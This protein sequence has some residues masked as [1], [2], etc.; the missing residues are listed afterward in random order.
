MFPREHRQSWGSPLAVPL[1]V[2]LC[3]YSGARELG[4]PASRAHGSPTARA[5]LLWGQELC[6]RSERGLLSSAAFVRVLECHGWG[7]HSPAGGLWR[8]ITSPEKP[9]LLLNPAAVPQPCPAEHQQ[10][11]G[12]G[13]SRRRRRRSPE[14][15]ATLCLSIPCHG[16]AREKQRSLHGLGHLRDTAGCPLGW[17][18]CPDSCRSR[19]CLCSA[20]P[21]L[22]TGT[23]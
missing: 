13:R 21:A 6:A 23:R 17:Q 16:P 9:G 14:S 4:C 8:G 5:V 20:V 18:L 12:P 19:A 1:V 3:S 15:T 2:T 10:L 22:L 11:P 7:K